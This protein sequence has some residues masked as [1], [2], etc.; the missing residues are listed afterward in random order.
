MLDPVRLVSSDLDS[1]GGSELF[2]C[3]YSVWYDVR[4][5]RRVDG[6]VAAN[7]RDTLERRPAA[8]RAGRPR[9]RWRE[10]VGASV[11]EIDHHRDRV[12]AHLRKLRL[13]Q[14]SALACLGRCRQLVDIAVGELQ[15]EKRRSRD[16]QNRDRRDQHHPGPAH[17]PG[18]EAMPRTL[19]ERFGLQDGHP[20]A[21]DAWSEDCQH[22]GQQRDARRAPRR[23]PRSRRRCPSTPVRYRCRRAGRRVRLRR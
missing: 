3:A 20:D 13:E 10:L 14:V 15:V 1:C 19:A 7:S 16:Q 12:L 6:D 17:D 2:G 5:E 21:V 22:R 18:R 9:R 23:P 8:A 11:L 4:R